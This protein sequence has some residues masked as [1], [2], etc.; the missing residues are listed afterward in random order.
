MSSPLAIRSVTLLCMAVG[1]VT[2]RQIV[3]NPTEPFLD[4]PTS[5]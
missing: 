2:L 3:P 4:A 1:R 5:T